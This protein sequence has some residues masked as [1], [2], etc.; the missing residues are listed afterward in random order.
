MR[1]RT[2]LAGSLVGAAALSVGVVASE[3]LSRRHSE[4]LASRC[5]FG[6]YAADEP[7]PNVNAHY[8]LEQEVGRLPIMSWFQDWGNGWLGDAASSAAKTGHDL[9]IAWDPSVANTPIDFSS[10]LAGRYDTYLT[11]FF[12]QARAYPRKVTLR[13]FWEMNGNWASYSVAHASGGRAVT[14]V[15]QWK[16]VWRHVVELQHGVGG[17]NVHFMF[18]ANGDDVGGIPLEAYWPGSEYVDVLGLDTYNGGHPWRTADQ[19]IKPMYTR[20]A[21]LDG[22]APIAIAE[23]GCAG[24]GLTVDRK[25]DWLQRLFAS[26]AFP[27]L[28]S[29]CFFNAD[30]Q[31]DWRI[32]SSRATVDVCRVYLKGKR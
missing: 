18:C 2:I 16:A 19:L 3:E 32:D 13:P 28:E 24:G 11:E 25:A 5:Q 21:R 29:I 6:A 27:R 20:L 9:Q 22:K 17:D 15:Q 26:D 31:Q 1:R 7:W 8:A 4:P 23:I 14:S 12:I 10:I 30:R